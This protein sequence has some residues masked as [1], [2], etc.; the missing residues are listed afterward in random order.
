M[1][2]VD[3]GPPIWLLKWHSYVL[4]CIIKWPAQL[5][6]CVFVYKNKMLLEYL[7]AFTFS[8]YNVYV[9]SI[10]VLLNRWLLLGVFELC[11]STRLV[12]EV[13]VISLNTVKHWNMCLQSGGSQY[14]DDLR[15]L[16][17]I[18]KRRPLF[19]TAPLSIYPPIRTMSVGLCGW[20]VIQYCY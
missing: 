10:I 11:V 14:A 5:N 8:I 20:P 2:H 15:L 4:L 3:L 18:R 6:I 17:R 19:P 13:V 16:G 9:G 12:Q 1:T 7:C